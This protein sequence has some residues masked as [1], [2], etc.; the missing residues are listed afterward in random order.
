MIEDYKIALL[1]C[2][3][4]SPVSKAELEQM[5]LERKKNRNTLTYYLYLQKSVNNELTSEEMDTIEKE[6]SREQGLKKGTTLQSTAECIAAEKSP[7]SPLK[8]LKK[9][10][11]T[12][13][14]RNL[15]TS[16]DA[17]ELPAVV[18]KRAPR[19]QLRKIEVK[20][21]DSNPSQ[22]DSPFVAERTPAFQS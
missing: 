22:E 3:K 14:Y 13:T 15:E 11:K 5:I 8:R 20:K 18:A 7:S 19:S 4:I 12:G 16:V 2:T 17:G 10:T 1:T 21:Q 9:V 6:I